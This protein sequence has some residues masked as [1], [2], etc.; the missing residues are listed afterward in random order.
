ML[1][2]FLKTKRYPHPDGPKRRPGETVDVDPATAKAWAA[3]GLV[4][5]AA[6]P[7]REGSSTPVTPKK[8]AKL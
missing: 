6:A 7:K 4:E 8:S 5:V 2:R 1:V 3:A